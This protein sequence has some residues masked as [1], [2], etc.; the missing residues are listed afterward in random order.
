LPHSSPKFL[1]HEDLPLGSPGLAR[2][3]AEATFNLTATW[4]NLDPSPAWTSQRDSG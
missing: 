4:N 1:S 3:S 2:L